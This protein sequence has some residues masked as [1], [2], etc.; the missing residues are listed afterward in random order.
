MSLLRGLFGRVLAVAA[1]S[2]DTRRETGSGARERSTTPLPEPR[3]ASWP[4]VEGPA[5]RTR[6][7]RE[8]RLSDS[9]RRA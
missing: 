5:Q 6:A 8:N 2:T 3:T 4:K 9:L 7:E 1:G